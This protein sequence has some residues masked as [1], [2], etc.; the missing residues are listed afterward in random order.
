[1]QKFNFFIFLFLLSFSLLSC[2]DDL[3][4]KGKKGDFS[5]RKCSS[6]KISND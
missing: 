5:F 6:C 1:M 3:N 2:S 4:N